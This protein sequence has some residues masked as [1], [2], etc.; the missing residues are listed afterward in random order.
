MKTITHLILRR[1]ASGKIKLTP[2][3]LQVLK[4]LEQDQLVVRPPNHGK[5]SAMLLDRCHRAVPTDEKRLT[6]VSPLP[7]RWIRQTGC[8]IVL[9]LLPV[10]GGVHAASDSSA[11]DIAN[12]ARQ[13]LRAHGRVLAI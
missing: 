13:G 8:L 10:T 7:G 11:M 5:A 1:V 6:I 9:A 2:R 12:D 4:E 3:L